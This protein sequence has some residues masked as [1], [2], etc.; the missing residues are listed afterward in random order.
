MTSSISSEAPMIVFG[1]A[2]EWVRENPTS[3]LD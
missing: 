2:T 3:D 1:P